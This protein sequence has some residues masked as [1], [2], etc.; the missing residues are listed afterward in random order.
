MDSHE[1][2][3]PPLTM[4]M[5]AKNVLVVQVP[6]LHAVSGSEEVGVHRAAGADEEGTGE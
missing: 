2:G 4:G 5:V 6:F 3:N 1:L